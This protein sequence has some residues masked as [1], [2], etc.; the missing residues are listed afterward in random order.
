MATWVYELRGSL[1]NVER[2]TE[3]IFPNIQ[4]CMAAIGRV[5]GNL[6]G[7]HMTIGDRTRVA[8]VAQ[9]VQNK[10][11]APPAEVWLIGPSTNQWDFGPFKYGGATIVRV[12]DA[13]TLGFVDVRA[14]LQ[15]ATVKFGIQPNSTNKKQD[16]EEFQTVAPSI[17]KAI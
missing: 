6:I 1:A 17:F 16:K 5:G 10:G 3:L 11:L 13:S 4:T 9:A 14:T 12:C 2:D 15:G 7:A 8:A